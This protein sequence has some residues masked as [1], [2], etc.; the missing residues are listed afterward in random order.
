MHHRTIDSPWFAKFV[1]LMR[2]LAF[3][4]LDNTYLPFDMAAEIVGPLFV[5]EILHTIP[6]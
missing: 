3:V 6:F 2:D 5:K 1:K 4:I